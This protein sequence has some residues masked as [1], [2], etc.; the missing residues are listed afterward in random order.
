MPDPQPVPPG[1]IPGPFIRRV[2]PSDQEPLQSFY[3]RLSPESRRAR[4]LGFAP[5]L[6][7]RLARTFCTPDHMHGEGFVAVA[8][9]PGANGEEI[10]GHLCLEPAGRDSIEVALAVADGQQGRGIGRALFEAAITW[11]QSQRLRTIVASAFADNSRVLRLL[12]SSPYPARVSYAE[13]GIVDVAIPIV[14][15]LPKDQLF[16]PPA[17]WRRRY[18]RRRRSNRPDV[19]PGCHVVW[20]RRRP[21][22]PGAE[23]S[24]SRGS[25]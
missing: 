17:E 19:T 24:A 6:D 2:R 14:P 5:G 11:A 16:L 4:F 13:G 20:R 1:G 3:A 22:G 25:S 9:A 23:G 12:S 18:A 7:I 8:G 10:V 21:P 15:E